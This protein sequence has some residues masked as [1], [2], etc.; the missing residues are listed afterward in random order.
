MKKLPL[1]LMTFST[2]STQYSFALNLSES[3]IEQ[4]TLYPSMAKIERSIPVQAGEQLVS[5]NGLAANFDINQ[6]QYQTSNIEVNAVS[7]TDSALDKP[8]GYESSQLKKQI[9]LTQFKISEQNSIIQAAELQNKFLGNVKEGA[10]DKVRKQTYDAFL[11]LIELK[12][13]R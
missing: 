13:K 5:L 6:L 10:A 7:H 3:P 11:L 2:L 8:A 9:E 4:V 1:I 12:V